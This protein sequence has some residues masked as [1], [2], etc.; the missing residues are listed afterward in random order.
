M[1]ACKIYDSSPSNWEELQ[2]FTAHILSECG[3]DTE[4][5]KEIE[6]VRGKVEVDVYAESK[7]AFESKIIFE[8]KYW[9]STIP[10]T[11]IHA[12]RTIINDSGADHGY[13]ISKAGFQ[14][15][16][17][18]ASSKSNISIL[19]WGQFQE[20]F[21]M[22]WLRQVI[23]RNYKT[24]RELMR[25]SHD[26]VTAWHNGLLRFDDA[27]MTDFYEKKESDF[28]FFTFKEHYLDIENYEISYAQI[29]S[30]ISSFQRR[31]SVSFASYRDF[32]N[33]IH[34]ECTEIIDGWKTLLS[35]IKGHLLNTKSLK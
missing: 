25:L 13:I 32:F 15:G 23:E 24:G 17:Y 12:F 8:C 5:E 20:R 10:Q 6:T 27:E 3:F 30:S 1:S 28:N 19:D 11:V 14:K 7:T 9:Q 31:Q 18:E 29:D 34:S 4:I 22:E 33:T 16:A 2:R 21:K 35:G 26:I